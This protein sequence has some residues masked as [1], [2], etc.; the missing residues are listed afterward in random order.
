MGLSFSSDG[1]RLASAGGDRCVK[2]WDVTAGHEVITLRS[3]T[4]ASRV[5]FSP[6]GRLLTLT[7]SS[8]LNVWDCEG[9]RY[10]TAQAR[11][12][13]ARERG[14]AWHRAAAQEAE[15][16]A[17]V[18]RVPKEAEAKRQSF[19]AAF[20][21]SQLIEA[22]PDQWNLYG[23]RGSAY[24]SVEQWDKAA[25]DLERAT[26]LGA[27]ARV[28][29]NRALLC[30]RADDEEGY[31]VACNGLLDAFGQTDDGRTANTVAWTCS[32]SA[33]SSADPILPVRLAEQAVAQRRVQ[34]TLNTLGAALYRAGRY[35]D[36]LDRLADAME[37][38]G[39]GGTSYDWLFLAMAHH[40]LGNAAEAEQWLDKAAQWIDQANTQWETTGTADRS[41]NW[42][43]RIE[44]RVLQR[45]AKS[46]LNQPATDARGRAG[47]LPDEP[48]NS[49][50]NLRTPFFPLQESGLDGLGPDLV[51]QITD[52]ELGRPEQL[53]IRLGCQQWPP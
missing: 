10:E 11:A 21:L 32:I 13:A 18:W 14:L 24:A 52:L 5:L 36:A 39:G 7:H 19:T 20:H 38:H 51:A 40:A 47:L 22:Q 44:L 8:I 3:N 29:Y 16:L 27:D 33:A 26:T 41:F 42:A 53:A 35:Q 15:R 43:N 46:T 4:N 49:C 28:W 34:A 37:A 9:E 12:D 17:R 23:R 2:L 48:D 25:A 45:E 30:L 50:W 1:K 6:D 31:R